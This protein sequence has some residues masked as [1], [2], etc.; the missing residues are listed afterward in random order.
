VVGKLK[1]EKVLLLVVIFF[2]LL[3]LAAL[4]PAFSLM[5]G[6]L[7]P[8]PLT[9]VYIHFGRRSGLALLALIFVALYSL[10]GPKQAALF[11]T[12]YAVLA[13]LMA[14]TIRF[15]FSFDKCVLLSAMASALLSIALLVFV[16][17]DREATLLE[18]FHEQIDGHFAQSIESLK[19]MGDKPE[20]LKMVQDFAAKASG[21]LA[22]AY[23]AFIF[24][25]SFITAL[26]NYY[27]IRFLWARIYSYNLFNEM[28]FSGWVLPDKVIWV[29]IG[30]SALFFLTDNV[31]ATI[32]INFLL[33]AMAAYFFQGLAIIIYFLESRNV[34][35]FFWVLIFFVIIIQPLLVGASIGLGVFDAWMDLRKVRVIVEQ[36][37]K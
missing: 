6:V 24:F 16:F 3:F 2:V 20:E 23:P 30:S 15:R 1:P 12:E 28:R 37:S 7:I 36:N 9:F 31:L 17:T 29:L 21:S 25:G 10:M 33:I 22:L 13:G 11:F 32:G 19:A 5:I 4:V 26:I 27:S 34:P 18:F 35:V 14:E 8:V